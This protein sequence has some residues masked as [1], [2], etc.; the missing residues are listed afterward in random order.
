MKQVLKIWVCGVICIFFLT[1]LG[2]SNTKAL[3]YNNELI[4]Y[5][6]RVIE[7]MVELTKTFD[8]GNSATMI[9]K[10]KELGKV[11]DEAIAGVTGMKGFNGDSSLRDVVLELLKFYK[12]ISTNE[13]SEMITIIGRTN[14]PITQADLDRIHEIDQDIT[15]RETLL[16]EK[17]TKIQ[18]AFAK[19][20]KIELIHNEKQDEIDA[21]GKENK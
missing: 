18:Q 9:P 8:T 20:Y 14:G 7:K 5:Q 10:L 17:M 16:D 13:Y 6:G 2:C 21:L 1:G 12:D 19:K 3:E 4:G 11:I 15:K